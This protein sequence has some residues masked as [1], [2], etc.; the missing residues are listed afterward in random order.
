[1]APLGDEDEDTA[2][3]KPPK[4]AMAI[5]VPPDVFERVEKV[6]GMAVLR[7]AHCKAAVER[8]VPTRPTVV[9]VGNVSADDLQAVRNR[10]L[11]IAAQVVVLAEAKDQLDAHLKS[12]LRAALISRGE[13]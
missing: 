13:L 12:A 8:M 9:V 4:V 1:M 11:D 5:G 7:P 3:F 2:R 6:L 10:A